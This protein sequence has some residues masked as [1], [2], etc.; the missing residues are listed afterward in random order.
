MGMNSRYF[1]SG[2]VSGGKSVIVDAISGRVVTAPKIMNPQ[3]SSRKGI[4]NQ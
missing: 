4:K 1:S 2:G 3:N